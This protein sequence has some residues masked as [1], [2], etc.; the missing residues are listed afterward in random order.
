MTSA[1]AL[2]AS[3]R[4]PGRGEIVEVEEQRS[5]KFHTLFSSLALSQ[6]AAARSE[7]YRGLHS[8]V[9]CYATH[10][11]DGVIESETLLRGL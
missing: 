5:N 3:I 4:C 2:E 1:T 9:R 7:S 10:C 11:E 6:P 8:L